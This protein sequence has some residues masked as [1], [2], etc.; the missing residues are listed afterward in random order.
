MGVEALTLAVVAGSAISAGSALMQGQQAKQTADVNAELARRQGEADKDA[1]VAQAEQI[2]K[3]ARYQIGA[4]NVAAAGSGIQIGEGSAGIV[5]EGI[6]QRS[7][8]DAYM[9]ILSGTRRQSSANN[10][11]SLYETQGSNA[12][13][14]SLLAAGGAVANGWKTNQLAKAGLKTV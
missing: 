4:A 7:E 8:N 2:R 10:Q 13:T 9:T 6:A 5:N 14:S 3:A 12:V 1:A 11:A